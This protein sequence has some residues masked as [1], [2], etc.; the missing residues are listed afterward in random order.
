MDNTLIARLAA[1]ENPQELGGTWC[2]TCSARVEDRLAILL[3]QDGEEPDGAERARIRSLII[4]MQDRDG[5]SNP[6]TETSRV[7]DEASESVAE[8]GHPVCGA[9]QPRGAQCR[10]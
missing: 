5:M 6:E 4:G 9:G 10:V 7:D 8:R 2:A 3:D 1:E